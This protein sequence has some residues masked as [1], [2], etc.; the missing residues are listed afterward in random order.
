MS[1]A[2]TACHSSA[3]TKAQQVTVLRSSPVALADELCWL[4]CVAGLQLTSAHHDGGDAQLL[5]GKHALEGL[6][7][8]VGTG[9]AKAYAT[10]LD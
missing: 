6:T 3:H 8:Q 10:V 5:E 9:Y 4:S 7:L 1:F 2:A